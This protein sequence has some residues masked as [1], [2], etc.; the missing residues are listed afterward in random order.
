M[1]FAWIGRAIACICLSV[2]AVSASAQQPW[3][4]KGKLVGETKG[5]VEFKKSKDV[6][7]IACDSNTSLPRLCLVIDDETQGAQIVLLQDDELRAGGFIPLT[8][9]QFAGK[10]L[11]L[12]AEG[13]AFDAGHFYVVGS[14]GRPRHGDDAVSEAQKK[15]K[16]DAKAAASRQIF[17]IALPASAVDMKT[18]Q[19]VGK[20]EILPSSAL[21]A[22]LKDQPEL[23]PFYDEPLHKN[24]VTIEGL[25]VRDRRLFIGMRGPVLEADAIVLSVA[26]PAAFDGQAAEP[27]LHRLALG[28][29]RSNH[30]R[31]VRDLVRYRDDFLV[32]AGPVNDPP[33]D[34][35]IKDGDYAIYLWNGKGKT[36]R[37]FDLKAFGDK[38]KPEALLPIDGDAEQVRLLLM[39][40]GPDEGAPTSFSIKLR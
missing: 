2:F 30:S 32:L 6:S 23:K 12:D 3:K 27:T 5:P 35:P 4:V 39:F 9:A 34:V 26:E 31:G 29:D 21:A 16:N 13:V 10:P 38:K 40:D 36:D 28:K 25:A 37:L 24:G 18:G 8:V 17:R 15:P 19:L 33:E 20:A 14:H 1:T 22:I 7:G 11:E